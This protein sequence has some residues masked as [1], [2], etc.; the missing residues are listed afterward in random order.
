MNAAAR[1][2]WE[3]LGRLLETRRA[4]LDPRYRVRKIFVSE[5]GLNY[6]LIRD[7]ETAARDNYK[8]PTISAIELAYR[9]QE[10]SIKQVLAGGDPVP[11]DTARSPAGTL[12][13]LGMS[14]AGTV[15]GPE[16]GG[17]LTLDTEPPRRLPRW[18]A[19]EAERRDMDLAAIVASVADL[20]ELAGHFGYTLAE[21]LLEAGIAT[22]DDLCL[23]DPDQERKRKLLA[24]FNARAAQILADP[25]LTRGQRKDLQRSY[26]QLRDDL[27]KNAGP[28]K[29]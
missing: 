6:G 10:G 23:P 17:T 22:A 27:E 19:T 1:P 11:L 3:R 9:W 24:E 28:P 7:I 13:P 18:L 26:E 16:P 2:K 25:Q 8:D 12:P 4:Q 21:L 5:S 20:R 15:G 14:A 29:M